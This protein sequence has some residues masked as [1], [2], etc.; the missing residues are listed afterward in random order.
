VVE[1]SYGAE[2][3]VYS[4]LEYAYTR[5]EG[6]VVLRLR[7]LLAPMQLMVFPLMPKD[8]LSEVALEVADFLTKH[9]LDVDYDESGT[10]GRRYARADEIGVPIS[11]TVDY[12]TQK[13]GTVTLRDRDTRDQVRT[14]WRSMPD[15]TKKFLHSELAFDQLGTPLSSEPKP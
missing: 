6:R 10:I 8:G 13:D 5:T 11:V 15:P 12:Q 14:N 7:R 3:I 9:D 4:T 1:P 2:R